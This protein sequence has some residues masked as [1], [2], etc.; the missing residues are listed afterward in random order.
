M[1]LQKTNASR[2]KFKPENPHAP[3]S[4]A[5]LAQAVFNST[6]CSGTPVFDS[7]IEAHAG[8]CGGG[9]SVFHRTIELQNRCLPH[10]APSMVQLNLS[11]LVGR[12]LREHPQEFRDTAAVERA[13]LEYRR[14]LTLQREREDLTEAAALAPSKLVDIVWHAHILQTRAYAADCERELGRFVH[15]KAEMPPVVRA[16]SPKS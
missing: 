7:M 16:V 1:S 9:L 2:F 14:F 8:H 12:I 15:R 10:T 11:R 4:V 3:H 13:T 5:A 6:D